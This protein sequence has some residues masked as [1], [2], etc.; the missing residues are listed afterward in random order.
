M[1]NGYDSNKPLMTERGKFYTEKRNRRPKEG[2]RKY[3]KTSEERYQEGMDKIFG[4]PTCSVCGIEVLRNKTTCDE[5][6]ES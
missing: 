1:I 3:Q 2:P 4:V 5:H 6:K